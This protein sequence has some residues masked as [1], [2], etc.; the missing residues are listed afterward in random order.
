M[1]VA[2]LLAAVVAAT[3]TATAPA[4]AAHVATTMV[5]MD[6]HPGDAM[7]VTHMRS[8]LTDG[9]V[10][11][12]TFDVP[13]LA[14]ANGTHA[15]WLDKVNRAL[16]PEALAPGS[17]TDPAAALAALAQRVGDDGR[18]RGHVGASFEVLLNRGHFFALRQCVETW[19]GVP[20]R[21]CTEHRI[22]TRS[23]KAWS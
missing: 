11:K 5:A 6:A 22:D 7:R 14:L 16:Q 2:L 3:A 8:Q 1:A 18:L 4:G 10:V 15:R 23:G 12:N 19:D 9:V 13:F 21:R 20:E 17:T